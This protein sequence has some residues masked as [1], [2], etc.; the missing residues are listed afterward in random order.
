[1]LGRFAAVLFSF[2]AMGL[3]CR[4]QDDVDSME[5]AVQFYASA[6]QFM[7][8]VLVARGDSVVF[9]KA[10]GS[11]SL[12]LG[13]PNTTRTKFR[14]G[15]LTKQF[16][17]AAV[18]LLEERGKLHVEDRINAHI[19]D[20]PKAWD[21]ITI[22]QL[23]T[24]TSGIPNYADFPEYPKLKPFAIA[25]AKLVALIREKPLDFAP[26]ERMNYSNSGYAVL[27]YMIEQMTG[28]TYAQF[29][30]ENF[31]TPLGMSD[32]GYEVSSAVVANRAAGYVQGP[33][34]LENAGFVQSSVL[35]SAA[36][37]Y[38]TTGDLLRWERGLFGGKI[39]SAGSLAKMTA[40]YKNGFAFGFVVDAVNSHKRISHGG[41]LDGFSSY[42]AYYP[43]DQTTVAV[44][45]NAMGDASEGIARELGLLAYGE[46][47]GAKSKRKEI[48][49]GA[50]ILARYVG[51]YE[52]APRVNVY[53]RLEDG[54]LTEEIT[55]QRRVRMFAETESKF[56]TKAGDAR[57]EFVADERGE[58]GRVNID[59]PGRDRTALRIDGA[60]VERVEIALPVRVL[61]QYVG[62]YQ[63]PGLVLNVAIENGQLM[64]R[65]PGQP[66]FALF[67]EGE[68]RFFLKVVDAR[69]EFVREG[70]RVTEVVLHQ[71][72]RDER[73]GRVVR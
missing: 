31:F 49:V 54:H 33:A 65:V 57:L 3:I 28:E 68:D 34:G 64:G 1:M 59:Q 35:Y 16:T 11:A 53:V 13:V 51:T 63:L 20:P 4:A 10:Y 47:L 2:V 24:H 22:F 19:P 32:S 17:A 6:N 14:I 66:P 44:L 37:L 25:P 8:S 27:G 45:G 21:K 62:E 52:I 36:G 71:G 50:D 40:P 42:L 12:E 67:A 38:S 26:G 61:E 41:G 7:G 73:G 69:I 72:T 9:D 56:F 23:L 70:E 48:E 18:L 5:E 15:S 29:L 39:L 30:Q 58:I 60:V 46:E 55:G 43:E